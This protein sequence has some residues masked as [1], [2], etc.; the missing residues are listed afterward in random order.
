MVIHVAHQ[1]GVDFHLFETGVKGGI[2]RCP[3]SPGG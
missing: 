3:P 2:D 1:H